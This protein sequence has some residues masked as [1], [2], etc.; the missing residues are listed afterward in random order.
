MNLRVNNTEIVPRM[1]NIKEAAAYIGMGI[2]KGK[3]WLREIG[4]ERRYGARIVRYD[5]EVIDSF[6]TGMN[7]TER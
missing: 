3:E 2:T 5:R 4:A 1:L 7:T 6:L